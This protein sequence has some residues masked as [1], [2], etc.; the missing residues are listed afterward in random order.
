MR[1]V[2]LLPLIFLIAVSPL[3]LSQ[4]LADTDLDDEGVVV[5]AE[6]GQTNPLLDLQNSAG[7]SIFIVNPDGTVTSTFLTAQGVNM[8]TITCPAAEHISAVNNATGIVTCS[9]DTGGQV[10]ANVTTITCPAGRH[11]FSIN[12]STGVVTCTI[13]SGGSNVT[14]TGG[15]IQQNVT[16][17]NSIKSLN[18]TGGISISSNAT[19]IIIDGSAV[20]GGGGNFTVGRNQYLVYD[21][22]GSDW[23]A[24]NLDTG[25]EEFSNTNEAH[26][27][28]YG[29]NNIINNAWLISRNTLTLNA[30]TG[31]IYVNGS[32]NWEHAGSIKCNGVFDNG[33]IV[34]GGGENG[35]DLI[36]ATNSY[37]FGDITGNDTINSVGFNITN[38]V[39]SDLT[40]MVMSD[41]GTGILFP[42]VSLASTANGE[43]LFIFTKIHSCPSTP[44]IAIHSKG[45]LPVNEANMWYG[46][47]IRSC[48]TGIQNDIGSRMSANIFNIS[49]DIN[50]EGTGRLSYNN[51]AT[52]G[53]LIISPYMTHNNTNIGDYDGFLYTD[54]GVGQTGALGGYL[55]SITQLN[56]T[57]FHG[58]LGDLSTVTNP[59]GYG[60]GMTNSGILDLSNFTMANDNMF[61]IFN[62]DLT[63]LELNFTTDRMN[64]TD[65]DLYLLQ[66]SGLEGQHI[67]LRN[68][69][70]SGNDKRSG[71][72]EFWSDTTGSVSIKTAEIRSQLEDATSGFGS[73]IVEVNGTDLFVYNNNN[74]GDLNIGVPI[75]MGNNGIE[76]SSDTHERIE[77]SVNG[78]IEFYAGNTLVADIRSAGIGITL[79]DIL[80]LDNSPAA[81]RENLRSDGDSII[82]EVDN[83]DEY[84]FEITTLNMFNNTISN[85]RLENSATSPSGCDSNVYGQI[86][87]DTD[88]GIIYVCDSVRDKWLSMDSTNWW[89]EETNSCAA[90]GSLNSASCQAEW[91]SSLGGLNTNNGLFLPY[92][93]T[94]ISYSHSQQADTCVTGDFSLEV[95]G[96]GNATD[97]NTATLGDGGVIV[98]GLTGEISNSNT[99]DLDIEGDQYI[100]W[101]IN[102]DCG[103]SITDWNIQF[104]MKWRHD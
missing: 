76:F 26:V 38:L 3:L 33:C 32:G 46:G 37:I 49:I 17:S 87:Y 60:I 11:V 93:A 100:I 19:D 53:N 35:N 67:I 24:V 5:Q 75:S 54:R 59:G 12:N 52:L 36:A 55:M 44:S 43:N 27:I 79:G 47:I 84:D 9:P 15:G 1:A 103:E 102:N 98:S 30:G 99:L 88:T 62:N 6:I 80:G 86:W 91:G 39:H 81:S 23:R 16:S 73:L 13:D 57:G 70:T 18:G 4:V 2:Y 104:F 61:E 92:N 74:N 20:A 51:E 56:V 85:V 34:F 14:S 77:S 90:A 78:R 97:D 31:S 68:D 21:A 96:S 58:T 40:F 41:F 45:G 7:S 64:L 42:A 29:L 22:G 8:T 101:G 50:S 71:T 89:G 65:K 28:Q 63:T 66:D 72:I 69:G 48:D 94:I 25:L 95:W 82:L 10:S 83:A